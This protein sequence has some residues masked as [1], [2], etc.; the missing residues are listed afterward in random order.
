MVKIKQNLRGEYILGRAEVRIKQEDIVHYVRMRLS[1]Y[2]SRKF[3]KTL[4]KLLY[5]M[6]KDIVSY[7]KEYI[8]RYRAVSKGIEEDFYL[9]AQKITERYVSNAQREGD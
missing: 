4:D 6:R 5:E 1:H 7:G 8:K 3:P 9:K 2:P